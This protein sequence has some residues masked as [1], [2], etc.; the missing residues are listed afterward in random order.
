MKLLYKQSQKQ[1]FKISTQSTRRR[2][3]LGAMFFKKKPKSNNKGILS[4]LKC[5][6]SYR[7]MAVHGKGR[8]WERLG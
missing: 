1:L 2:S 3:E 5:Q 7:D 4:S 8:R 6:G